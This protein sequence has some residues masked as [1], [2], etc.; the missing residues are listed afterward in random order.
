[1]KISATGSGGFSG[2]REHY[3]L[4]TG[5][6]DQGASLEAQLHALDFFGAAPPPT[7]GADIGRWDITVAD[8]ARHHTVTFAEDGSPGSAPWQALVSQLR[9]LA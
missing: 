3:E 2:L 9:N 6:L 5:E 8:G 4:D 7:L 1:M